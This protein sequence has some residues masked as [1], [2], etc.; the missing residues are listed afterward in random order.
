MA[1]HRM[2]KTAKAKPVPELK[3]SPKSAYTER[4]ARKQKPNSAPQAAKSVRPEG[5]ARRANPKKSATA[6]GKRPARRPKAV[7]PRRRTRYSRADQARILAAATKG[8][9]TAKQ[10]KA[11]FGVVPVTYYSWR[12]KA[13]VAGTPAR[14]GA[15]KGSPSGAELVGLVREHVQERLR[16]T[17]P[18]IVKAEVGAY[19]GRVFRKGR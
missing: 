5:A 7:E 18:E 11:K 4:P 8:G 12:M 3:P 6:A 10:V 9:L 15:G 19:L 13:R 17:L 14:I 1:A 16:A 2:V